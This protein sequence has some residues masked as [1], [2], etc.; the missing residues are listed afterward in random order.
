[1][2]GSSK[3]RK[4]A[5]AVFLCGFYVYFLRFTAGGLTSFFSDD[6]LMNLHYYWMR[7]WTYT[8]RANLLFFIDSPR[9]MGGLYYKAIYAIW[10]FQPVPYRV[11]DLVLLTLN[12]ALLFLIV[13]LLARSTEAGALALLLTGLNES[14]VLAYYDTGMVY[15]VL[16]FFFLF[17]TFYY[18]LRIRQS[19]RLLDVRQ[20][21]IFLALFIA[22]MNSKE[23]SASLPVAIL[24]YELLWNP[25]RQAWAPQV[26]EWVKGPARVAL[27]SGAALAVNL[28][29]KLLGADSMMKQ[30]AYHPELHASLFLTNYAVYLRQL[31]LDFARPTAS[32]VF[33]ILLAMLAI[34][35]IF[36]RRHLIF[37]AIMI[38]V[39]FLPLAFIPPRAGFALYVPSLYWS[40]WFAGALVGIRKLL[41]YLLT[42]W[43]PRAAWL[44]FPTQAALCLVVAYLVVPLNAKMFGYVFPGIHEVQSRNKI[45]D[46]Q[47]HQ[48]LPTIPHNSKILI[49]N[50]PYDPQINGYDLHFMIRESYDD[51]TLLI[52]RTKHLKTLGVE[53]NPKD[54]NIF[55]DYSDNRFHLM[56]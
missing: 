56:K 17:G 44:E 3:L 27:I 14:F 13:R 18:Y 8:L 54:F 42:R 31:T 43:L 6:D 11:A 48:C 15:D 34:G 20:T 2:S 37:A 24:L 25:P 21:A 16:A 28:V 55:L 35:C 12:L 4:T 52:H 29:G 33:G 41:M 46:Q 26:W 36:R 23:V 1:M 32:G 30:G 10:G 38:N 50:D 49:V 51:P 39:S 9:P 40:L 47:I 53:P 45:A 7:P 5:L 22:A 19:G